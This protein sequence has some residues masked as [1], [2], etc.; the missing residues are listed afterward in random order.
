M[1]RRCNTANAVSREQQEWLLSVF[2]Y[3]CVACRSFSE[4]K[5]HSTCIELCENGHRRDMNNEFLAA[6]VRTF[7]DYLITAFA[8]S[9]VK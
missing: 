5:S 7:V 3:F 1:S 8:R 2:V 9:Y 4:A 6:K